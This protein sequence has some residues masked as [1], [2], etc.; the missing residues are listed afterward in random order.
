MGWIASPA[1]N[2]RGCRKLVFG[3]WFR[4]LFKDFGSLGFDQMTGGLLGQSSSSSKVGQV[5]CEYSSQRF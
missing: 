2:V 4:F 5:A 3:G 1:A